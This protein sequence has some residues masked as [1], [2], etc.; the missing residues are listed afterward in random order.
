VDGRS[1]DAFPPADARRS[2][3]DRRL[4]SEGSRLDDRPLSDISDMCLHAG[5]WINSITGCWVGLAKKYSAQISDECP[6]GEASALSLDIC[7][8]NN[9]TVASE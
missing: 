7:A 9:A 4:T 1:W 2:I 6:K 8:L 5:G 3:K